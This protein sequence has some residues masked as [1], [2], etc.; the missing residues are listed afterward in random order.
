[1]TDWVR[2]AL[3]A[4]NG[5]K[6]LRFSSNKAQPSHCERC[7]L[8]ILA[9]WDHPVSMAAFRRLDPS[10]L[11]P[12]QEA[13]CWLVL[14]KPTFELYGRPGGWRIGGLRT[15]PGQPSRAGLPA[16]PVVPLHD[17]TPPPTRALLRLTAP[18]PTVLSPTSP[19]P[20]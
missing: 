7:G 18:R 2:D 17:C 20:F 4:A 5:G 16:G 1:M 19:P 11:T 8:V 13:A 12:A 14:G 10:P 9:G 3:V 6:P 15:R